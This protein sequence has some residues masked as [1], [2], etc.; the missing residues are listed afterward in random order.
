MSASDLHNIHIRNVQI[1]AS[2]TLSAVIYIS[3]RNNF[4]FV[5]F[6]EYLQLWNISSNFH[7]TKDWFSIFVF[8]CVSVNFGRRNG[9]IHT[10]NMHSIYDVERVGIMAHQQRQECAQVFVPF[11]SSRSVWR[12]PV[13]A[14]WTIGEP[15][16]KWFILVKIFI[17]YVYDLVM[18][19]VFGKRQ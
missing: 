18:Y 15:K 13:L 14:S 2:D 16:M 19:W 4:E 12:T 17:Q 5:E 11:L 7:T 10:L 9:M 6:Q 1:S 8:I 3:I